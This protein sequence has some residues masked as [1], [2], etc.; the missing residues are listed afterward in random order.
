MEQRSLV[1]S[2]EHQAIRTRLRERLAGWMRE[3]G[4]FVA[5]RTDP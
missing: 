3:T 4:D 1:A 5:L 2:A